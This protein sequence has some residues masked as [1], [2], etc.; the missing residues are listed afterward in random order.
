MEGNL[1]FIFANGLPSSLENMSLAQLQ[2]FVLF[3]LKCE[4][5]LQTTPKSLKE[6][7][8]MPMWWPS[9]IGFDDDILTI[10]SPKGIWSRN[11]RKVIQN[12]YAHYNCEFLIELSKRLMDCSQQPASVVF[13]NNENGTRSMKTRG[14]TKV[15]ATFTN[16]NQ[17]YEI[18]DFTMTCESDANRGR[19]ENGQSSFS[20]NAV[21][22]KSLQQP[23]LDV[24]FCVNREADYQ[25]FDGTRE[26]EKSYD[27]ISTIR[28]DYDSPSSNS[29]IANSSDITDQCSSSGYLSSG[30]IPHTSGDQ[31]SSTQR[32]DTIL[33][34]YKEQQQEKM[35]EYLGLVKVGKI[36][37][38]KKLPSP[39]SFSSYYRF[40]GI[41][42]SSL[43]GQ[44]IIKNGAINFGDSTNTKIAENVAPE[45]K[46][47][48]SQTVTIPAKPEE[49][50]DEFPI[51]FKKHE[52]PKQT[53]HQ[54]CFNS[55]QRKLRM[56]IIDRGL[57]KRSYDLY[58]KTKNRSVKVLLTRDFIN[59]NPVREAL[60]NKR[61]KIISD[62]SK[63]TSARGR[64]IPKQRHMPF[65]NSMKIIDSKEI[66][67]TQKCQDYEVIDLCSISSETSSLSDDG[68]TL[69]N[70]DGED[71]TTSNS[72]HQ[73]LEFISTTNLIF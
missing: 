48:R 1:P 49:Q 69:D 20:T 25:S 70:S 36:L 17:D 33:A 30:I 2:R 5:R 9:N 24:N 38:K 58:K 34:E 28:A 54:Y 16:E 35:M 11:M 62:T 52:T 31:E 53:P 13:E 50:I 12:C 18:D 61:S 47:L 59:A 37:E 14:Q 32:L 42:L 40:F 26:Y 63:S 46:G 65:S 66:S 56:K 10:T 19:K 73:N 43:L 41:P 27:I 51:T 71:M 60:F 8:S 57:T 68:E 44:F 55:H 4:R 7:G 23:Q 45:R 72:M 67:Q 29:S 39:K 3:L 22:S 6:A 21:L 15:L 64:K